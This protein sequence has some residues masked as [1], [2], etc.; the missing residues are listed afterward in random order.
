MTNNVLIIG[1]A[2]VD[3][4]IDVPQ[5]PFAGA[6]VS[7]HLSATTIGGCAYN[8]YQACL[9]QQAAVDLFVPIGQGPYA[10][11]VRHAFKQHQIPMLCQQTTAD[12][13]WDLCFV[14]PNGERSFVTMTG[15]EQLWQTDWFDQL[16]LGNSTTVI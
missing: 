12:N 9:S 8:V 11:K 10:D 6:D 4:I 14:E 2:F 5:L 15:I 3:V 1:A 13:G 7:G 16:T